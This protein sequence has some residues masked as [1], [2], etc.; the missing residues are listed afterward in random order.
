MSVHACTI[1]PMTVVPML[2]PNHH[3]NI[4]TITNM[5]NTIVDNSHFIITDC[6]MFL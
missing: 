3:Q 2:F 5:N 1:Q 6:V 4:T